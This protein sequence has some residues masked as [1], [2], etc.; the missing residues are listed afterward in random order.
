MNVGLRAILML[1][2]TVLFIIALFSDVHQGDL[3]AVGLACFAGAFAVADFG[4]DRRL[5]TRR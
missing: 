5:G 4:W 2:A 1:A 3:I